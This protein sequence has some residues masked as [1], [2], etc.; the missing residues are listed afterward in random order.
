MSIDLIGFSIRKRLF[1]MS[2]MFRLMQLASSVIVYKSRWDWTIVRWLYA[3]KPLVYTEHPY[4]HTHAPH[5]DRKAFVY[6]F[7]RCVSFF[8]FRLSLSCNMWRSKQ[9]AFSLETF[10][11]L[12][13]VCFVYHSLCLFVF[14][15]FAARSFDVITSSFPCNRKY[16][17]D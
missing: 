8:C 7:T 3:P 14:T 11:L 6:I 12:P 16:L 1:T 17:T 4:T 10:T 2:S 5:S 13:F 9:H 15:M